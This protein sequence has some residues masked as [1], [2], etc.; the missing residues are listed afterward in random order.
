MLRTTSSGQHNKP[1]RA[2]LLSINELASLQLPLPFP[3]PASVR[4]LL[5]LSAVDPLPTDRS[6]T[7]GPFGIVVLEA[8]GS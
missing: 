6:E 1:I 2:F 8:Q 5:L 3:V 7:E 4:R